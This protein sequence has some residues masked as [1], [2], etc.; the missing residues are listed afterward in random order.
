MREAV[1]ALDL[2]LSTVFAAHF[3]YF[4]NVQ[5]I[6]STIHIPTARKIFISALGYYEVFDEIK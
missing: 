2:P 3:N 5:V 4:F 1:K 6:L